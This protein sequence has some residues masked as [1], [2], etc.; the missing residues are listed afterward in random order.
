MVST[1][2]SPSFSSFSVGGGGGIE[3]KDLG[4]RAMDDNRILPELPN[5][6]Q[7]VSKEDVFQSQILVEAVP[8]HR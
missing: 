1:S 3:D 6:M 7:Q 4:K 5:K 8:L 2:T